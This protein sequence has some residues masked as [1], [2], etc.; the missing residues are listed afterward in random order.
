MDGSNANP[1][2]RQALFGGRLVPV[3]VGLLAVSL[4]LVAA[5]VTTEAKG[6]DNFGYRPGDAKVAVFSADPGSS[7]EVRRASDDSVVYTVLANGGS[8]AFSN[9]EFRS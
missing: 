5:P 6:V 9:S 3:M 8:I 1:R 2:S 7:V 4:R